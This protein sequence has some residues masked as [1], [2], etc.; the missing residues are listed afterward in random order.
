MELSF[1]NI[2]IIGTG[3]YPDFVQFENTEGQI[4]FLNNGLMY[5]T[6]S[7]KLDGDFSDPVWLSTTEI[8]PKDDIGM[9]NLELK[10]LSGFGIVGS[11][12]TPTAHKLIIYEFQQD[13][14]PYLNSGTISH[15]VDD[16]ISRFNLTLDNPDIKD[17]E[18]PGNIAVSE[19]ASLLSPGSRIIFNF[20]IGGGNDQFEMGQF[21]V[22][23]NSFTVAGE[24][25]STEGRNTMGKI[26]GDQ[27]VDE[28]CEYWY[29][30]ISTNI[31]KLLDNANVGNSNYIIENTDQEGWFSFSPNTNFKKGLETMLEVLPQWQTRELSDGTIVVGNINFVGFDVPGVYTFY[32]GKD[33]FSRQITRDDVEAYTRVCVHTE[34]YA[35]VIFKSVDAYSGWNLKAHKTLYVQVVNGLTV[36]DLQAYADE[37]AERLSNGGKIESFTGPFRPHLQCG[38]E[39]IIIGISNSSKSLGLITDITHKFGKTGFSTDFTV[40][41]GGTVGKGRLSDYINRIAASSSTQ[42]A[43]VGWNDINMSQYVNVARKAI[44]S[45]SADGFKFQPK[46]NMIDGDN[47]YWDWVIK[48]R[49][50]EYHRTESY[51]E[52]DRADVSPIIELKFGQRCLINKVKLY[53][54]SKLAEDDPTVTNLPKSYTLQY[55][56]NSFWV[57]LVNVPASSSGYILDPEPIHEFTAVHT[58]A[59]RLVII[60]TANGQDHYSGQIREIEVWG[61]A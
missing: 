55:W 53:F 43:E 42:K 7:E 9:S 49:Y 12:T 19:E 44:I 18:K 14:S 6:P 21:F 16:P 13:I 8:G 27:T 39:A 45:T 22:D 60:S 24:T 30:P 4:F 35:N 23:R 36:V 10:T 31:K 59:V 28:F 20:E 32:R 11:Y 1:E 15:S 61:N 54:G 48:T 57:T 3:N 37:L 47:S 33:I 38:D 50:N 17:P 26:L 5:G 56:N 2:E 46:T 52:A 51:W 34:E 58:S 29:A 40:D 25:A 41:S